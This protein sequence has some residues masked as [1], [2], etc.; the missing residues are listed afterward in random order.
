ML[1]L[2]KNNYIIILGIFVFIGLG[3]NSQNQLRKM[4]TIAIGKVTSI[5]TSTD[6]RYYEYIFIDTYGNV[7]SKITGEFATE[8]MENEL[9]VVI[10]KKNNPKKSYLIERYKLKD[11]SQINNF[12]DRK[13]SDLLNQNDRSNY[14]D[15]Q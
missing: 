3:I 1:K 14:S 2:L 4:D 8:I 9:Y 7:N 15:T 13:I 6:G 11:S 5:S 12:L 10:Y